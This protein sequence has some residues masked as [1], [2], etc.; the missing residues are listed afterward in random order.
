LY[1]MH[2]INSTDTIDFEFVAQRFTTPF[3]RIYDMLILVFALS[4]GL[5][6]MRG[7]LDDYIQHRGWRVAAEAT[8]WVL[9]IVFMVM[10]AIVLLTFQ[11]GTVRR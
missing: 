11:P 5:I 3:W 2:V 9:G 1:I 4:H 7:V 10:G 6:G 8:L